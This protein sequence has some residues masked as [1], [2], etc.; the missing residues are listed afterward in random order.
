MSNIASALKEEIRRLAK[1]EVKRETQ[2]IRQAVAQ[3]RHE[4]AKLKRVLA[5]QEKK[6]AGI[7]R[8]DAKSV[9][10]PAETADDKRRFSARS[11]KSQRTRLGL[12]A[13]DYGKLVGVSPLTI[14]AWEQGKSRPRKAQLAALAAVRGIGKRGAMQK[15]ADAKSNVKHTAPDQ[16]D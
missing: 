13:L 2:K 9:K 6:I 16:N 15:L 11:V 5:E 10:Q 8:R 4:I 12:S 3:Y 14:Y 7:A 1:R